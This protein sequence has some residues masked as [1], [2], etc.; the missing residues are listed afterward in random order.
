[1]QINKEFLKSLKPCADRYKVFLKHHADFDG[2]LSEFLDLPNLEYGD[3]AWVAER[4]L[5]KNQAIKWAT[6]CAESVV[7]IFEE[8]CPGNKH[9]RDCIDF[10]KTVNDFDNLTE[11]EK[12][13]IEKHKDIIGDYYSTSAANYATS[14]AHYALY[15]DV[16]NAAFAAHYA[17]Y[18]ATHSANAASDSIESDA[19]QKQE[20]LNLQFLKQVISL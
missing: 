15:S 5:N 16:Y 6:L 14:A 2:S 18:A 8:Q 13:E 10:L 17:V 20:A 12:L 11:T 1:M 3:K 7:H 4:V 9:P 19:K